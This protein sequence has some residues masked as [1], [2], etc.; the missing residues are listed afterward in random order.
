MRGSDGGRG[1]RGGG[2]GYG[3]G[4]NE[5]GLLASLFN[6]A[7]QMVRVAVVGKGGD[8]GF[9]IDGDVARCR[10]GL[11][12]C[13]DGVDT[14]DAKQVVDAEG[15]G[16]EGHCS[17]GKSRRKLRK[18]ECEEIWRLRSWEGGEGEKKRE[19]RLRCGFKGDGDCIW[20]Q[21]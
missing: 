12:S 7:Q 11:Q 10:Y 19:A 5:G 9:E 16:C 20:A 3:G 6:S 14:A 4:G 2:G 1:G 17:R 21:A 13:C 18:V 15:D 8:C